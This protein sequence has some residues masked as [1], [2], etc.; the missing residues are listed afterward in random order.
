MC[1]SVPHTVVRE[2]PTLVYRDP[3]R[4]P[5]VWR[6][7]LEAP[8]QLTAGLPFIFSL[9]YQDLAQYTCVAKLAK[10]F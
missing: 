8:A 2:L 4:A 9:V 5:I 7:A 1:V 10:V 3:P 6:R